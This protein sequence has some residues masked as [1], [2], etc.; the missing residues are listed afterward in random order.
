M[1]EIQFSFRLW[2]GVFNGF[3]SFVCLICGAG[4]DV[5]FCVL[6][7]EDLGYFFT[8]AGVCAGHNIDLWVR[9]VLLCGVYSSVETYF[10]FNTGQVFLSES[11]LWREELC[12]ETRERLA[13]HFSQYGR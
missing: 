8:H 11:R 6:R 12:Q 4:E 10:S 1:Y 9:R 3:D 13:A 7:I 2:K 5:D